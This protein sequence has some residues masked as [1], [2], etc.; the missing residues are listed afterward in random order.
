M[1]GR[2]AVESE[3]DKGSC[4]HFFLDL[5][6]AEM[7]PPEPAAASPSTRALRILLAEDNA[8][9]R[10]V[11]ESVLS[12]CGHSVRVAHNGREAVEAHAGEP[13]DL[14][15]MD[16][17]MPEVGGL[18]ATRRIRERERTAGLARVPVLALTANAAADD[19]DACLAAGMDGCL[20]KPFQASQLLATVDRM[21]ATASAG[22]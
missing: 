11:A 14:I 1:G 10:R 4:F 19:R 2:L 6:R 20:A 5:E 21:S 16:L 13:F 12:K 18:E 3:P 17:Q 9:N 22:A 7:P 8:V 15:L